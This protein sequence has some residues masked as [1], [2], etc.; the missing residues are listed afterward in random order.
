MRA[1]VPQIDL[2]PKRAMIRGCA[3][4]RAVQHFGRGDVRGGGC[5]NAVKRQERSVDRKG[6]FGG[7]A[8]ALSQKT[9][10]QR[11]STPRPPF[12][13]IAGQD[14]GPARIA[15]HKLADCA[16]LRP[17]HGLRQRQM[18]ADQPES[19]ATAR[20]VSDDSAAM[21]TSGQIK[22]GDIVDR[23]VRGEKQ[24]CAQK[25]VTARSPAVVGVMM[26]IAQ[27]GRGLDARDVHQATVGGDFCVGLLQDQRVDGIAKAVC[28]QCGQGARR[29]NDPVIAATAVDVPAQAGKNVVWGVQLRSAFYE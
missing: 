20:K 19:H 29:I 8:E 7:T 28:L 10:R 1:L 16:Q 15:E 25:S 3:D 13:Q 23:D 26:G 21:A 22:Q 5:Q 12:V 2:P 18:H 6:G 24:D 27:T 9:R 14:R 11:Q 4:G 17:P